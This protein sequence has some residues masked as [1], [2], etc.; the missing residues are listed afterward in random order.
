ME[1]GKACVPR[2]RQR[3]R[4]DTDVNLV[5]VAGDGTGRARGRGETRT[6]PYKVDLLA[7]P[8]LRRP[9]GR[10]SEQYWYEHDK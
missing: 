2:A 7:D 10:G 3:Q 6:R 5:A 8:R 4:G 9:G 1:E